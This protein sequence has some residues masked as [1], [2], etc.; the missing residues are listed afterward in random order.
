MT[1]HSLIATGFTALAIFA[2]NASQAPQPKVLAGWLGVFPDI[3]GYQRSF[4]KP[5]IDKKTFQQ[6][7]KYEWTGGR[8]E[9]IHVTLMRI[10]GDARKYLPNAAPDAAPKDVD[11]GK[12]RGR[13][14]AGRLLLVPLAKDRLAILVAPTFKAHESDLVGFAKRFPLGACD[15]AL[16]QPP[17]TTFARSVEGFRALRKGMSQSDVQ[18]WVGDAEKDIGSGIHILTYRL[19]DGSRVLIGFPDFSKL[20]YIKHQ[21]KAGKVVDLV[22]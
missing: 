20:I 10:D 6:T 3:Q 18:A 21:D 12:Y 5:K 17:R 22:K 4:E 1:P 11:V 2:V 15:N 14:W 13:L 7:A 19:D 9:T 8:I 16:D